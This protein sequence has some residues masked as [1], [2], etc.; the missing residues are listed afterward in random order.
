MARDAALAIVAWD[1]YLASYP[2]G[3]FAPEA[4]YN[5]ALTL[6][7]LGRREEARDALRPFAEADPGGYRREEA[8]KLLDA[9]P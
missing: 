4:R 2:S 8:R 6:V 7:R 1:N 9:I 3:Q 5:R